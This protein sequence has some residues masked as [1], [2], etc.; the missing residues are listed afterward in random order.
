MKIW[1]ERHGLEF[2]SFA[3]ELLVMRALA[4][5][6]VRGYDNK[7]C[8]VLSFIKDSVLDISLIDPANSNNIISESIL[9][10]HK[11][12]IGKSLGD[13]NSKC[14]LPDFSQATKADNSRML[15][16]KSYRIRFSQLTR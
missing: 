7:V 2:K 4:E 10:K 13:L 16:L 9:K 3:L 8:S 6:N 5:Q 12:A 15:A 14:L 11:E 1:R